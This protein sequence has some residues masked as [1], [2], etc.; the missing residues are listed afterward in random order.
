VIMKEMKMNKIITITSVILLAVNF[1]S[2]EVELEPYQKIKIKKVFSKLITRDKA[3]RIYSGQIK[4]ESGLAEFEK[5]YG[6]DIDNSKVDFKKQM[7]IFGLTDNIRTR[8]FQFLKQERMNSFTLDYTD[9]GIEYQLRKV[10]EGL[11]YSYV[12]VFLI[13][14]IDGISHV[15]VKNLVGNGLSKVYD[16]E[17]HNQST[18]P[19]K[20][21]N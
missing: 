4:T 11:K 2:A 7:L 19:K 8:A 15:K 3:D 20:L 5:T 18:I 14:Q 12:Q 17:D 21:E 16:K 1:V 6:I 13:G 10:G 9:T